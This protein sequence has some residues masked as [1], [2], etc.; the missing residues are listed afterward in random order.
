MS[1]SSIIKAITLILD[2]KYPNSKVSNRDIKNVHRP[3]FYVN[4][5][6]ENS[7]KIADLVTQDIVSFDVIY[8]AETSHSGYLDLLSKKKYLKSILNNPIKTEKGYITVSE[9]DFNINNQDYVLNTVFDVIVSSEIADV[10]EKDCE[11]IE[12]LSVNKD[13]G[14][15]NYEFTSN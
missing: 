15:E 11:F 1:E 2:A 14:A 4:F 12:N 8:F 13:K 7:S 10:N 3:C 5:I 6:S 9:L